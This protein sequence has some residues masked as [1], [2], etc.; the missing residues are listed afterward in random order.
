[1]YKNKASEARTAVLTSYCDVFG[2][3]LDYCV[4][5]NNKKGNF[6]RF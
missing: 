2:I 6:E 5:N 1:M 4:E 3:P